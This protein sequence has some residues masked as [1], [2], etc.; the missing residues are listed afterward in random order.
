MIELLLK[1]ENNSIFRYICSLINR[2]EVDIQSRIFCKLIQRKGGD[3]AL[4]FLESLIIEEV[5]NTV[6]EGTLLRDNNITVGLLSAHARTVGHQ[7]LVDTIG[8]LLKYV[9]SLNYNLEIDPQKLTDQGTDLEQLDTNRKQLIEVLNKYLENIFDSI[10]R[11]PSDLR[12][13]CYFIQEATKQK[14]P[15]SLYT[16]IGGFYFLR[17][18]CPA[19]T[20]PDGFGIVDEPLPIAERRPFVLISKAI[21]GLANDMKYSEEYMSYL[22]DWMKDNSQK[23]RNFFDNIIMNEAEVLDYSNI[24][25]NLNENEL[26]KLVSVLKRNIENLKSKFNPEESNDSNDA[27][28]LTILE[29]LLEKLDCEEDNKKTKEG[30]K[31][32]QTK[33]KHN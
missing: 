29:D 28:P 25:I 33:K 13:I 27:H 15:K 4:K 3:F 22:S 9:K 2:A 12:R 5:E 26:Q 1:D 7:Y 18:A 16:C 19:I 8:P 20:A 10:N 14:F 31:R 17:F 30:K 23:I 21:Q 32:K 11:I 6:T 24:D